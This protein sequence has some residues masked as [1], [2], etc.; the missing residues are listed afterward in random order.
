M[1]LAGNFSREIYVSRKTLGLTQEK[2]AELLGIS[3]RW[4]QKI[5]NGKVLPSSELVLRIIAYFGIDGTKLREE[6]SIML[7][8]IV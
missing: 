6:N 7:N 3:L 1:S 5:E 2:A 4:Y 8:L